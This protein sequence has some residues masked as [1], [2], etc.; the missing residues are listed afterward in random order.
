MHY[1]RIDG[2][3]IFAVH[4]ATAAARKLAVEQNRCV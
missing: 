4:A 1:I 3:D 2:N